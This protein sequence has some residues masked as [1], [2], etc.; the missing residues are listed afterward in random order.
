MPS[1]DFAAARHLMVESQIKP[2]GVTDAAVLA[3]LAS[4]PREDFV[5]KGVRAIAYVDEDVA[6]GGGRF[7]MEPRVFAKLLQA[8]EVE[9]HELVLDIACGTGYSTAVLARLAASV[10]AVESDADLVATATAKLAGI[11]ATNATV[12]AGDP[13]LGHPD[14]GPYDVIVIEG[15]VEQVPQAL[16]DQLADDGR[17]LAVVRTRRQGVATLFERTAGVIGHRPLF[18]AGV[19]LLAGFE[20][21][22]GFSF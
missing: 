16:L 18:D 13:R 17:L 10:V 4:T 1:T 12:V 5:P 9:A 22:P 14:Q 21:E 6:V 2:N 8:A 19:P 3:A 20:L 11:G 15:A 7:L